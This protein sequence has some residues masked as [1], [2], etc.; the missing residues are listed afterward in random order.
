MLLSASQLAR[1][2][3]NL[4]NQ[5]AAQG[6]APYVSRDA[7]RKPTRPL[8]PTKCELFVTKNR[9]NPSSQA[10]PNF[11]VGPRR[12]RRRFNKRGQYFIG[13]NNKPLP[14][15]MR[16][17]D[18]DSPVTVIACGSRIFQHCCCWHRRESPIRPGTIGCSYPFRLSRKTLQ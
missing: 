1:E 5:F 14:V 4:S 15:A 12:T 6:I 10:S 17:H 16:V 11:H 9:T 7:P 2:T 18:P 3:A 13:A 8:H